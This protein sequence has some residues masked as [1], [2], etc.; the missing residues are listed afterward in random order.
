[1]STDVFLLTEFWRPYFPPH[2]TSFNND[3]LHASDDQ[4]KLEINQTHVQR[5]SLRYY[6]PHHYIDFNTVLD[7]IYKHLVGLE[8][9]EVRKRWA[10]NSQ[11]AP[12]DFLSNWE[13]WIL[14][15]FLLPSNFNKSSKKQ[16]KRQHEHLIPLLVHDGPSIRYRWI[17]C[18]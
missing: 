16:K 17:W 10:Q 13:K 6:Y 15:H 4:V 14:E 12:S 7:F 18:E 2:S 11:C 1:M 3:R 5:Q 8:R 9:Q